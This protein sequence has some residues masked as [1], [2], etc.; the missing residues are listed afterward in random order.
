VCITEGLPVRD[1]LGAYHS[2]A[3]LRERT[4]T[5]ARG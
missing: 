5:A 3:R 2:V 1:T 4:A